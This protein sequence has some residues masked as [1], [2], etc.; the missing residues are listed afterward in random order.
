MYYINNLFNVNIQTVNKKKY[1]LTKMCLPTHFNKKINEKS[2]T[3]T[4]WFFIIVQVRIG[5][6]LRVTCY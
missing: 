2:Q 6:F 5:V 4:R 1:S 3:S